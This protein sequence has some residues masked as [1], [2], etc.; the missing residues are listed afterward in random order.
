MTCCFDFLAPILAPG[1]EVD[2]IVV[3]A[4][5]AGLA[6]ALRLKDQGLRPVILEARALVGGRASRGGADWVHGQHVATWRYLKRFNMQMDGSS[7]GWDSNLPGGPE[8]WIYVDGE[9]RGPDRVFSEPNRLFF[10]K[11]DELIEKWIQDGREDVSMSQLGEQAFDVTPTVDERLLMEGMM[12]EWHAAD[13]AD[14]GVYEDDLY[15]ERIQEL[16]KSRPSILQDDGDEGHWRILGGHQGL[17]EKMSKG[18][19]V[20]FTTL[21]DE[22]RWSGSK[23][24]VKT[25]PA[26]ST[27]APNGSHVF[28]ARFAVVTVPLACV[29]D[30]R[31]EPALPGRKQMAVNQLGRGVTTTVYLNFKKRFWPEKLAFLFHSM[32]SQAFWPGRNQNVLTAYFGGRRANEELLKLDDMALTEEILR[33]LAVIFRKDVSQEDLR[34]L[35]LKSEV[36]RWDTDP[37]AKMAYS[38]CPVNCAALRADLAESCR[39]EGRGALLLWAGEATHPTK[40]SFAH[41]ALEEGERAAEEIFEIL[42]STGSMVG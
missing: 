6:C 37:F 10:Q 13:L 30:I 15:S 35:L 39:A 1:E 31:F 14:V 40:A 38:Y 16:A 22:I 28:A 29:N 33:Q 42:K 11:F 36:R 5:L 21:V 25:R 3:G 19:D 2:V 27:S 34:Q 18:L 7:N 12:A 26:N 24:R 4:G 23:V 32:S 9:L 17:A 20:R 8:C 41:G